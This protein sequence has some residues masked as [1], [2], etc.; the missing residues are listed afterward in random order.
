MASSAQEDMDTSFE[1]VVSTN[2]ELRE[3]IGKQLWPGISEKVK[4]CLITFFE[5]NEIGDE[6]PILVIEYTPQM[7]MVSNRIH[8]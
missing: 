5:K 6:D 7:E 3:T 1:S 4:N 8:L 2:Q